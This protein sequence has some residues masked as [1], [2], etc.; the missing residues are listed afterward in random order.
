MSADAKDSATTGPSTAR[1]ES[2][3]RRN[4]DRYEQRRTEIV[5]IA[6][7]LF[8]EQGYHA[9]S[10]QDLTDA[11]GLQRG[12]LYHYIAAKKDLLY[13]IHDRFIHPLLEEFHAIE[14]REESP[15]VALRAIAHALMRT[16]HGKRDQVTVFLAEWR[17]IRGDEAWTDVRASRR[18][19][20]SV[21][22]RLFR[23]GVDE[24]VFALS[25]VRVA[26]LGFL[27]MI[28]WGYTWV[29]PDGA[30][31]AEFLADQFCDIYLYGV[32][33][34]VRPQAAP[35]PTRRTGK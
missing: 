6:S 4:S 34:G 11:V 3:R 25:N 30:W 5:D 17:V 9:T 28:N 27:G 1:A 7:H 32:V 12:A 8:A 24:G 10:M 13:L 21:V 19:V 29:D 22:E 18:E 16:I 26:T 15:E 31:S 20:E 2:P 33:A 23:R 14:Q 35:P